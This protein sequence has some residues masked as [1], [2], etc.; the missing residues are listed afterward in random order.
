MKRPPRFELGLS[1]IQSDVLHDFDTVRIS[2]FLVNL[3]NYGRVKKK[4]RVRLALTPH[5]GRAKPT[6]C[7]LL[8]ELTCQIKGNINRKSLLFHG[9]FADI[10]HLL[11][12]RGITYSSHHFLNLLHDLSKKGG[13]I[14]QSHPNVKRLYFLGVCKVS[15]DFS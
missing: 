6:R 10:G 11:H 15:V 14:A 2:T 12:S 13:E 9:F 8:P 1:D 3:L 7:A 4:A 5:L